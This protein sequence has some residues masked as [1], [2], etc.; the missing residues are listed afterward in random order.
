MDENI[1]SIDVSDED[2]LNEVIEPENI[3]TNQVELKKK[4]IARQIKKQ[5]VDESKEKMDSMAKEISEL[6]EIMFL[7][8][9]VDKQRNQVSN[10]PSK[11][12]VKVDNEEYI[13]FTQIP[14][15]NQYRTLGFEDTPKD[16]RILKPLFPASQEINISN[17]GKE[18]VGMANMTP[19]FP[20][21]KPV[22]KPKKKSEIK[23]A[24]IR[25][26]KI[27][28]IG[29]GSF[30]SLVIFL[31]GFKIILNTNYFIAGIL[32]LVINVTAFIVLYML[33]GRN[34][35]RDRLMAKESKQISNYELADIKTCP[36]CNSKIF[37]S[38]VITDL[39]GIHQSFK[40]RSPS[41]DFQ[42]TV[43]FNKPQIQY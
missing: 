43:E 38:K 7:Q 29:I 2:G 41:C 27:L 15:K 12:Q 40:C 18:N 24:F 19:S 8:M 14:Q 11:R 35:A 10:I 25:A 23:T 28:G 17:D 34:P 6:K 9:Q 31:Y 13:D 39:N 42:K 4:A 3:N 30:L 22:E 32:S 37:K 33:Y 26:M 21:E 16:A 20:V 36:K 5:K 1:V